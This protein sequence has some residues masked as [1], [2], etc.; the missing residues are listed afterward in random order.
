MPSTFSP[1]M[2][3]KVCLNILHTYDADLD[4]S[5]IAP[6]GTSIQL[7]TDNGGA[8]DNYTNTCFVVTGVPSITSGT[9]PFTGALNLNNPLVF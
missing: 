6:S 3:D 5:L 7:S 2:L 4:I 9:P 8:G 1:A